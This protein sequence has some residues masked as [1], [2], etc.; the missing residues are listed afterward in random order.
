MSGI[1]EAMLKKGYV[2]LRGDN[3]AAIGWQSEHLK[4]F[5]M[6]TR[7]FMENDDGTRRIRTV[8]VTELKDAAIHYWRHGW[9]PLKPVDDALLRR[10]ERVLREHR[11]LK[12]E[13][14]RFPDT[15][16]LERPGPIPEEFLGQAE[17]EFLGLDK[18]TLKRTGRKKRVY[19]ASKRRKEDT[20][21]DAS[22]AMDAE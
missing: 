5:W 20:K 13:G 11:G 3:L 8:K 6:W 4:D 17:R 7:R 22:K 19:P 18:K 2:P 9:V 14:V 16:F 21:R 15:P 1:C 12:R 10:M